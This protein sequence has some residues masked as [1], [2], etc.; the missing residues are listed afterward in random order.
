MSLG[1][2][3]TTLKAFLEQARTR[4]VSLLLCSDSNARWDA[5]NN[6]RH[7]YNLGFQDALKNEY[8]IWGVGPFPASPADTSTWYGFAQGFDGIGGWGTITGAAPYAVAED[9]QIPGA[10]YNL[11]N[12]AHGCPRDHM[13][14]SSS[15]TLFNA[16]AA[17]DAARGWRLKSD[18]LINRDLGYKWH[19]RHGTFAAGTA[20]TR[21]SPNVRTTG[22]VLAWK[23]FTPV[24][25]V[26]AII[27]DSVTVPAGTYSDNHSLV[28]GRLAGSEASG[29]QAWNGP[30]YADW[31]LIEQHGTSTG[32]LS[33]FFYHLG[34]GGAYTAAAQLLDPSGTFAASD[35]DVAHA[36]Y[37][38][39]AVRLQTGDPKLLVPIMYG[40]NDL[41][42]TAWYS[43][44][45][46]DS[47]GPNPTASD[48]IAGV[49]DNLRAIKT[50]IQS[51]WVD[52]L[53]FDAGNIHFAIGTYQRWPSNDFTA[54]A[55]AIEAEFSGDTNASGVFLSNVDPSVSA[56]HA[57]DEQYDTLA[58]QW[59]AT[60]LAAS[61]GEGLVRPAF[62]S[63]F[64][65]PF[66]EPIRA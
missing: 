36:E 37:L 41:E 4:R 32:F 60:V 3:L 50:K 62:H 33:G 22:I 34:S 59:V 6:V 57:T 49:V 15:A 12:T 28:W 45:P 47:L 39:Q 38:R 44:T 10:T 53:G 17:Q 5:T 11:A 26:D 65:S 16:T 58:G 29:N 56:V 21:Y 23:N 1:Y 31:G 54:L 14:T 52:D 7:G 63:V 25:G 18:F 2:N 35:I 40:G 8:G 55:T 64:R 43:V 27:E 13:Y 20:G 46:P 19:F 61:E 30:T 42:N 48:T 24:T 51:L 9:Y 66:R